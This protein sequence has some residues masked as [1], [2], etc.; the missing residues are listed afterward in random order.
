[1]TAN[2]MQTH[3]KAWGEYKILAPLEGG[4]RNTAFLVES[5]TTKR[6]AK[7]TRR[8][9]AAIRW[10][11]PVHAMAQQAGFVTPDLIATRD[12]TLVVHGVTLETFIEGHAPTSQALLEMQSQIQTFHDLTREIP[13][14]PGFAS[15]IE[16]L[17]E[18][19]GGDVNLN[20]MPNEL[21]T[22]CREHWREHAS[23]AQS[24]VHG[25]LNANNVLITKNGRYGLVDWDE[26]RVDISDFDTQALRRTSGT[27]LDLRN[28]TWLEAWEVAVCWQVEPAY[29]LE[30]AKRFQTSSEALKGKS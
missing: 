18:T 20:A 30:V 15:S 27:T 11:Q 4:F 17:H 9:E 14:R 29:A 13:Q 28:T 24:V 12:G 26:T 1:M 21:V 6:V 2:E 10:L 7:T 19:S 22:L 3:L 23:Q 25:D 5:H 8:S 16:L